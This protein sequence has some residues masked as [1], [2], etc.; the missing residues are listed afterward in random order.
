MKSIKNE[1]TADPEPTPRVRDQG[2]IPIAMSAY[3]QEWPKDSI[4][5][6]KETSFQ[7]AIKFLQ[8]SWEKS[9]FG[10]NDRDTSG[11]WAV[12]SCHRDYSQGLGLEPSKPSSDKQVRVGSRNLHKARSDRA[13]SGG[14]VGTG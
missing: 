10:I 9:V 8:A 2:F 1:N 4:L 11:Q 12:G 13:V 3:C 5:I 14:P 6:N 7:L